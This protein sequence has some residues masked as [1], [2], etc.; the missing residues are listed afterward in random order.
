MLTLKL[1]MDLTSSAAHPSTFT[2]DTQH[3][4]KLNRN[5]HDESF[6]GTVDSPLDGAFTGASAVAATIVAVAVVSK[7]VRRM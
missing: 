6:A 3:L 4:V 1:V 5:G 7:T 2:I